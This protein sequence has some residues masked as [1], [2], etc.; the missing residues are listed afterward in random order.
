MIKSGVV[1]LTDIMIS[2]SIT[3][4]ILSFAA[5]Q[6]NGTLKEE[7]VELTKKEPIL[8]DLSQGCLC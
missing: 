2:V 7:I 4:E 5:L 1:V 3:L 6:K 8:S